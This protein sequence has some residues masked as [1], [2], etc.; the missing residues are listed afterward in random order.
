MSVTSLAKTLAVAT[1]VMASL[2]AFAQLGE[3]HTLS[4]YQ[5][6]RE[7]EMLEDISF[8]ASLTGVVQK[9]S[10]GGTASGERERAGN[11]RGDIS[12]TLPKG[13]I[14]AAEGSIFAHIRFG[15]G[16]GVALRP[17]YTSTPNTVA[18]EADGANDAFAVLAQA[19]Y[20]LKIP[21]A[22]ASAAADAREHLH[23]T[24]GKIDPFV[25]FDQNAVA[26]D[27]SAK[28]LNNVFVHN[29]LLDSGRDVGADAHGFSSG[30][31]LQYVN[32]VQSGGEWGLSLGVLGT[33]N[34]TNSSSSLSAPLVIAQ[35]EK[36]MRIGDQP[37]GYRV[38][39]W[40]NARATGY[41]DAERHDTG[42]GASIDQKVT[43]DLTLFARFGHQLAGK[44]RFDR[45]LT[46]GA[47]WAGTAWGRADD[48]IGWA[49]GALRTSP[50][51]RDDSPGLGYQADGWERQ[52]EVYYRYQAMAKLELSPDVQ[53]IHRPGG[54]GNAAT[55]KVVG[56]RAKI[57]F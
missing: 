9:V 56:M 47:E 55:I 23:V 18:F 6:Q 3:I 48:S 36:K 25:F 51:F 33:S 49:F 12:A 19:W 10:R 4:R 27:E 14:G 38:Y 31:I 44:V 2:P 7:V 1:A 43:D 28:F 40:R 5:Q 13:D 37:G 30:V 32:E 15:E 17:T 22:G 57:A 26:D 24:V 39:L 16:K 53:L 21:L 42:V 50:N 8:A 45:A 20:Q 29:P 41:D 11:Y 54:D 34:G 46:L 35:A 52:I